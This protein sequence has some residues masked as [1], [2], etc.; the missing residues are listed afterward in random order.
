MQWRF[1]VGSMQASRLA[2]PC[3]NLKVTLEKVLNLVAV[4]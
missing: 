3:G 2:G 4:Y 1:G